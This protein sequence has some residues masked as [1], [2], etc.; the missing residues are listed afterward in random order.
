MYYKLNLYSE[1]LSPQMDLVCRLQEHAPTPP[2]GVEGRRRLKVLSILHC[3][4]MFVPSPHAL[5]VH[6]TSPGANP[7]LVN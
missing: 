3:P 2:K 5:K 1:T 6:N 7:T 4:E